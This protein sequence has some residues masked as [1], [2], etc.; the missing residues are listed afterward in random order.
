MKNLVI[1]VS[2]DSSLEL[3]H[4]FADIV[5][6]DKDL[7]LGS[8]IFYDTVYI[9]SHFSEPSTLPQNFRSEIDTLVQ[10]AREV[11]PGVKFIDSMDT[12]DEIV[13]FEDKWHQYTKFQKFMPPTQ[14]YNDSLD[15]S[16]FVRPVYKKRLS[17]RGNGVTWDRQK[18]VNSSDDWII[19]ES[20]DIQEELRVYVIYGEVYPIGAV[21]QSMTEGEKAQGVTYRT[22]T[23]D[24][25]KFSLGLMEQAPGLDIVGID[26]ARTIDGKLKLMEVNR[27]PGFAKF[28]EL[29]N[30]NLA[31][32]L[33]GKI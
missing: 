11:N 17:S 33:Y 8:S 3:L 27:S 20:L 19:Q 16:R 32:L 22:L 15:I 21:K 9:R 31:D 6:L 5:L 1:A 28:K 23:K 25:T 30:V 4:H 26:I 2:P 7:I 29:T 24:E 12:V 10:S 13:T 18:V 14:L